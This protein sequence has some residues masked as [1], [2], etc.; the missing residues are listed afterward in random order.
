MTIDDLHTIRSEYCLVSPLTNMQQ[1]LD[2]I[3]QVY[4]YLNECYPNR[5]FTY[6][7]EVG[8]ATGGS[9][10]LYAHLLCH[11]KDI[12]LKPI[13]LPYRANLPVLLAVCNKL[14]DKG[15]KIEPVFRASLSAAP[16]IKEGIDLLHI[17]AIHTYQ[18][19]KEDFEAFYPKVC[20][21]GIILLHDTC[22][23]PGLKKFVKELEEIYKYKCKTFKAESNYCGITVVHKE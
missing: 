21:N 17:D 14:E 9:L 2:E 3:H 19:V 5:K 6:F 20:K 16:L 22:L 13:E 15:Y 11:Q 8:S 1:N 23:Y 7:V 12:L 10:W 4:N 18:A